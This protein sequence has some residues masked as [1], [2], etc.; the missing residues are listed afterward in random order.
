MWDD[1]YCI[2]SLFHSFNCAFSAHCFL[3]ILVLSAAS[4]HSTVGLASADP[5]LVR[6]LS[7]FLVSPIQ[8]QVLFFLLSFLSILFLSFTSS[9]IFLSFI[10]YLLFCPSFHLFSRFLVHA[11]SQCVLHRASVVRNRL[12]QTNSSSSFRILFN[13][14][15]VLLSGFILR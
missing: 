12:L 3:P 7:F 14:L 6:Y 13:R 11:A 5:H 10:R 4:G 1:L 8:V 9:F 15:Y 2:N